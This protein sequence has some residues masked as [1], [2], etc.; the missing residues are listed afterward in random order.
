MFRY[1]I[2]PLKTL[3]QESLEELDKLVIK[4]FPNSLTLAQ[5]KQQYSSV[6]FSVFFVSNSGKIMLV[7]LLLPSNPTL[8]LYY[9]CVPKQFRSQGIFKRALKYLKEVFLKQKYTSFALDASEES[10]NKMNQK[11]R[12]VIFSNLGFRLSSYKNPSPFESHDDPKTY[13]VTNQGKG[14]LVEQV[15]D[16]YIVLL[17]YQKQEFSLNQIKGCVSDLWSDAPDLCPLTMKLA[18]TVSRNLT[19]K[20][21]F[22]KN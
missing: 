7:S 5:I 1:D 10:D 18:P 6:P 9:I 4:T 21:R 11:K 17:N 20:L 16:K 2:K 12:L 19:R 3:D 14:E 22:S 13:V 15:G 8:Y